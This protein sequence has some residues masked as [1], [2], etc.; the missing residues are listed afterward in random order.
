[1]KRLLHPLSPETG[2]ATFEDYVDP[3]FSATV[4][5][6]QKQHGRHALPWQNTRDAYLI[7]LS[8]IMLQQT[9]VA[10]VLAYYARFL[11]RFPTLRSLAEAPV[12]DV[13]AQWSGLGYYTR[14]R[15]LHKCAQRVV[16][17][18]D[19]V[20]PSDP[21]LLADLPGIGRSTAAA[22]SAFSSGTRAAIMDGNVKRVFARVFGIDAYPGEK[23]VE[24][25][26]WRRAVALLPAGDIN[27]GIESYTQGLMDLGATLCTRSSP[28][29]GRCPLQPRCVAYATGRTKELPV[30]KPKKTSPEKHAMMLVIVDGGQVLLQQRPGAGIWGGLLSLPELD[31]HVLRDGE[32]PRAIDQPALQRA[33]APFGEI[34]TQELLLPIV[35]VFTH[36]KLHIVPCRITLSRRL[37]MAA[38][39]GYV[40][41]AGDKVADAPLPAPIKKLLL[42]LFGDA[43]AAQ[44]SM[45]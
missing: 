41:L 1:M 4:I 3:T 10:A 27:S 14:A 36:Y 22:I 37:E 24:E 17:E 29:C 9:Q 33:V 5:A 42:D 40:W 31:G 45:F 13:M 44:R 7:W 26:M 8:E 28:D 15:N 16:N 39:A 25:A 38:E 12:E 32:L 30:R 23:K 2:A 6:W 21:A 19:G 43:R 35:H 20:F 34:E 18:Y 11:T